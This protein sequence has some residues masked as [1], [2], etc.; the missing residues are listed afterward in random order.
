MSTFFFIF[1]REDDLIRVRVKGAIDPKYEES[2][3][4]NLFEDLKETYLDDLMTKTSEQ[5]AN[6]YRKKINQSKIYFKN[7]FIY[8]RPEKVNLDKYTFFEE[9]EFNNLL[10]QI[11]FLFEEATYSFKHNSELDQFKYIVEPTKLLEI[12]DAS[13]E[14]AANINLKIMLNHSELVKKD[15]ELLCQKNELLLL[16]SPDKF[17]EIIKIIKERE[18]INYILI[19]IDVEVT[20]SLIELHN[21]KYLKLRDNELL[22]TLQSIKEQVK[23]IRQLLP[24]FKVY[25]KKYMS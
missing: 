5:I 2:Y 9:E 19:D 23:I 4:S 16:K 1:K 25:E 14:T 21:L 22:I 13:I 8:I 11:D 18:T 15:Y 17:S 24:I 3:V 6:V 20:N 7:Q 12:L 10:S